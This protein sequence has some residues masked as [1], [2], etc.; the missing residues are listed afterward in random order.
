MNCYTN[1]CDLW[2]LRSY[3]YS[4][5]VPIIF[6]FVLLNISVIIQPG[7][8]F[9]FL[10]LVKVLALSEN[11]GHSTLA[12]FFRGVISGMNAHT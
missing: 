10:L 1:T 7:L 9:T 11:I 4:V 6:Q 12:S 5:Y 2:T 3:L 8:D